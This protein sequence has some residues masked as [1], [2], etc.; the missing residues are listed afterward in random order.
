MFLVDGERGEG[1]AR[2]RVRRPRS[3]MRTHNGAMEIT[4]RLVEA[5]DELVRANEA[6]EAASSGRQAARRAIEQAKLVAYL[7]GEEGFGVRPGS[8]SHEGRAVGSHPPKKEL[9]VDRVLVGK[10]SADDGVLGSI[11]RRPAIDEPMLWAG[12][13]TVSAGASTG[14]HHHGTNTTVFYMLSGSLTVEHGGGPVLTATAEAGD[15]VVVPA[16]VEHREIVSGDGDVEAIVIRF[17]DGD[18]PLVVEV[19]R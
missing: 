19:D 9:Q 7:A 17:G 4:D 2:I 16:G 1:C 14:W 18:G 10:A 15:F 3:R 12:M 6:A 8:R 5:L 11:S 13:S